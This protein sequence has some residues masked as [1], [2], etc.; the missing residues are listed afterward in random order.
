MTM[1]KDPTE[2]QLAAA[3]HALGKAETELAALRA[4]VR[5]YCPDCGRGDAAP[6]VE[7]LERER[8]RAEQAE[9]AGDR[10]RALAR[11]HHPGTAGAREKMTAMTRDLVDFL[12]ARLADDEAH[13]RKDLWA[14]DRATPG[15][16][17]ARYGTNLSNSW[18]ETEST[19]VL[20][21]EAAEH[22]ADA[23]LAARLQP[24]TVRKRAEEKLRDVDAK[25]QMLDEHHDTNDG[26]CAVCVNGHWGYPTHGGSSPQRYPCRTLRLLALPYVNHPDY[27][28]EWTP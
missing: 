24:E 1:A 18:V 16:W 28:E 20:R 23:L 26:D 10:V 11:P 2:Q 19:P 12:R 17:R 5:G 21:L 4:V 22:E 3:I 15:R 6:T 14:A 7:D 13:A 27:R 9:V 8:Q 25:R